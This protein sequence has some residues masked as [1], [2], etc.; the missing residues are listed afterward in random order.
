MQ[1]GRGP[2]LPYWQHGAFDV[3]ESVG[4]VG[5]TIFG[6]YLSELIEKTGSRL[7]ATNTTVLRQTLRLPPDT[8]LE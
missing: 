2:G 1:V 5:C 4:G 6:G 8:A 3:P 7:G